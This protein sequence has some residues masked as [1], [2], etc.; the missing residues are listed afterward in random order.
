MTSTSRAGR[1]RMRSRSA[2]LP[3]HIPIASKAVRPRANSVQKSQV[4]G[5]GTGTGKGQSAK[6]KLG[7][8]VVVVSLD[9]EDSEVDF[10][11][12]PS[13]QPLDIP[14]K[15][16]QEPNPPVNVPAEEPQEPNQP[17]DIPA[18]EPG[19][20]EEP[21]QPLNIPAEGAE[22][23]QEPNNPNPLPQ[24]PPMP[25]ANNQ[26]NWSHINLIFQGNLK[27]MWRHTC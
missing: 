12:H 27:K 3:T 24:H 25:M 17:L 19:E 4:K 20:L 14:A 18:E 21:N 6:K 2:Q 5:K 10:P 7:K 22:E 8:T 13:N 15:Q 23:P 11:S 16:P 1:P 9:S 26:L